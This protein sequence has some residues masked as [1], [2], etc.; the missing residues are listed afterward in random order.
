MSRY[1]RPIFKAAAIQPAHVLRDEPVYMDLQAAL[2]RAC[3]LIAEAGANGA[4]LVVFP[5]TFL[6]MYPGFWSIKHDQQHEWT[7]FWKQLV[8]NSVE[9]PSSETETLCRAAKEADAYVVIGINE[10]DKN[11]GC[12]MYNSA[13]FISPVDGVLGVHRKVN[14]TIHEQLY[15]MRGDGGDNLKVFETELGKIGGL[16]CG[17]H[18]QLPL[19]YNMIIQGEEINCSL[20]PGA[21]SW[22]PKHKPMAGVFSLDTEIQITTR[23]LC[24]AGAMFTVSSCCCIPEDQRP[25]KVYPNALFEWRGGSSIVDPNGEYVTEPLYDVES[26]VYGDINLGVIPQAKAIHN[27]VGTYGRWD[28]FALA[29]RQKPYQPL[30]PLEHFEELTNLRETDRNA[31]IEKRIKALE[32]QY[33][34][35][36]NRTGKAE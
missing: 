9:V 30:I 12:R 22:G 26:I 36:Y 17:E 31:Q 3:N 18:L 34:A 25:K 28:L 2:E 29:I 10:L 7:I 14:P 11:Y 27:L 4:K 20:W 15:H 1:K 23:T 33:E 21:R 35:I 5:E 16:I 24:L 19:L 32:D 13:L 8:N 6:P